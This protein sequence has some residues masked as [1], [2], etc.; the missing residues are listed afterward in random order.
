L[1]LKRKPRWLPS[2]PQDGE[3]W[4]EGEIVRA[5]LL[6]RLPQAEN[7]EVLATWPT[8]LA[9]CRYC[10]RF[11]HFGWAGQTCDRCEAIRAK[12]ETGAMSRFSITER[13]G[14]TGPPTIRDDE[15]LFAIQRRLRDA[16]LR[17]AESAENAARQAAR[18]TRRAKFEEAA[19]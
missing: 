12:I 11:S 3:E 5:A 13:R 10:G 1:D 18:D 7:V 9:R 15:L 4:V 14:W 16:G 8:A 6:F 2:A 17:I 19:E